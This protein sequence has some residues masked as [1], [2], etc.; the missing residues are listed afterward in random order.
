[1]DWLQ[2]L[3]YAQAEGLI[4]HRVQAE[5]WFEKVMNPTGQGSSPR[6]QSLEFGQEPFILKVSL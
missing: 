5:S 1:M 2:H 3:F 4:A 6:L